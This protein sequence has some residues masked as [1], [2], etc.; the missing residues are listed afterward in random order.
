MP[1]HHR[2][3]SSPVFV[4]A[5]R[6]Q[7]L[8]ENR[9]CFGTRWSRYALRTPALAGGAREERSGLLDHQCVCETPRYTQRGHKLRFFR[10][11]NAQFVTVGI[12]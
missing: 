8:L 6:D 9:S 11:G 3:S 12:I 5:Y 7:Q 2:W 4:G 1:I 10:A